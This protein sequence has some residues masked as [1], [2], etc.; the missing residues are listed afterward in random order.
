MPD[1]DG[2]VPPM[3]I[4]IPELC[5]V[6]LIGAS[7]AGKSTFAARHFIESEVISSDFCRKLVSDDEND[8]TATGAAFELL[9]EIASRRLER[10]RMTVVDATSVRPEDR[11]SIVR[12]AK[13]HHVFACAI[14]L[15]VPAEIC[16]ARNEARP[17]RDFGSHVIRNQRAALRRSI[18]G[19]RKE[20]FRKV[21]VL[22]GVEAI[23]AVEIVARPTLDRPPRSHRAVRHHRRCPRLSHRAG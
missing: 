7:G 17:D 15:D 19:L 4:N 8:Q 9:R 5:V 14:V 3:K 2:S 12:L 1:T 22:D 23:D 20:G 6:V 18:R 16:R 10:G 21:Y 11:R 13:D